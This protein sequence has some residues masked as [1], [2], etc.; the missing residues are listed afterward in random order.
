MTLARKQNPQRRTTSLSPAKRVSRANSKIGGRR[1]TAERLCLPYRESGRL[2]LDGFGSL[3]ANPPFAN[4]PEVE[5][6][7]KFVGN[8]VCIEISAV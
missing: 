6:G 5:T 8:L 1:G 4:P 3:F 7:E 2:A